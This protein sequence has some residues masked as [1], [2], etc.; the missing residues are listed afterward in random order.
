MAF[1]IYKENGFEQG[2]G[3]DR[4]TLNGKRRRKR[5]PIIANV[6]KP[7]VGLVHAIRE[8]ARLNPNRNQ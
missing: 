3:I 8:T 4:N 7:R 5:Q 2:K 1:W 6:D